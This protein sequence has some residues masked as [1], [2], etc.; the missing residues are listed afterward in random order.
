M[1]IEIRS[2]C[3]IGSSSQLS[4]SHF[5]P[6]NIFFE[7]SDLDRSKSVSSILIRNFPPIFCAYN[8]LNSAVRAV[9]IWNKPVG[10]GASLKRFSKFLLEKTGP[11]GFEPATSAVT[12]R[13]SNQL[14]YGPKILVL[15]SIKTSFLKLSDHNTYLMLL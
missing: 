15:N 1:W 12:G 10:L 14:N 2:L 7:Y 3:F 5:K 9:P 6:S 4:P 13:C 8:Q 11:T